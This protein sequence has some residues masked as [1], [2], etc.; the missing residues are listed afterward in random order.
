MFAAMSMLAMFV[1]QAA[2]M[3]SLAEV[4][5]AVNVTEGATINL[6]DM[7]LKGGWIMGVLAVL[8]VI[9]FY[10]FFERLAVIRKAAKDD[11]LFMER[12][13]DYIRS[14]ETKAAINFCR[15][16]NTPSARMIEKGITR[17]AAPW[18][19]CRQLSRIPVTSRWPN[20]KTD[21]PSWPPSRA[22][23]R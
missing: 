4:S 2:A 7:C 19:T 17:M 12:I 21:S 20:W 8:S 6:W 13:R 3:D 15:V 22:A 16:T 5:S 11:P 9:C 14:G 1:A 23:H 10:I 18:P